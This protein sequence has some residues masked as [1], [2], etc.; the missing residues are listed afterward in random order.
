M[1]LIDELGLD[2]FREVENQLGK[3]LQPTAEKMKSI[4]KKRDHVGVYSQKQSGLN[5]VGLHIPVGRLYA[6]DLFELA[7]M[8]EVYGSSEIRFSRAKCHIQHPR[9]TPRSVIIEPL[10]QRFS[11]NPTLWRG[12]FLAQALSFV[13][14]P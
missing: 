11:V 2:K 4:G 9:F 7:R 8:A 6:Q 14:L 5:Y 13:T 3:P 10:L 12:W 1:W